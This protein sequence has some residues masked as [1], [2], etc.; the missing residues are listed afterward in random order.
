MALEIVVVYNEPDT[1]E[2]VF[3]RSAGLD[4]ATLVLIDNQHLGLGLPVLFNRHLR[5]STAEWLV[6]CHQDFIVFDADW[7][8]RIEALPPD[9]CYGPIGRDATQRWRG[10]IVQTDGSLL[11]EPA[12]M[13]EVQGV[14]EVCLVVPRPIYTRLDFDEDFPFDLYAHD[15][16]LAARR[17]GSPT[18]IV[19]LHC[20]H[21]SKTTTGDSTSARYLAAK[22]RFIDKHAGVVPLVTTTFVVSDPP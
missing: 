12:P 21:R 8:R 20:Q 2:R 22:R 10:Q 1:L 6:F 7:V 19:D 9:A 11:G 4:E 18:R 16:C 13:A 17:L 15:Y 5:R 3:L 14:D